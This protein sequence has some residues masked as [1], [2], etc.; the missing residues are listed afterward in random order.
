MENINRNLSN[1]NLSN[2]KFTNRK[3]IYGN[4][5]WKFKQCNKYQYKFKQWNLI[6][7]I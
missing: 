6:N 5:Q 1:G 4:L 7:G 2:V 3:L